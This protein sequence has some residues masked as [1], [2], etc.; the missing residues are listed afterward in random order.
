MKRVL[1]FFMA[2]VFMFALKS[3]AQVPVEIHNS[4]GA[5]SVLNPF[6]V[7]F[8]GSI[9]VESPLAIIDNGGSITVD[10]AGTFAVQAAQSGVWSVGISGAVTVSA[11][12]LDMRDLTATSDSIRIYANTAK[13][14]SG[15]NYVP[16]VDSDGQLQVD[17]L[18]M[19]AIT[20][21][22]AYDTQL[23]QFKFTGSFDGGGFT[24]SDLYIDRSSTDCVG[25]FGEIGTGATVSNLNL[26]D[27]DITGKARTGALAG[28]NSGTV[29]SCTVSGG[30]VDGNG[31][32]A[33]GLIGHTGGTVPLCSANVAVVNTGYG[34]G[35]LVGRAYLATIT[36]SYAKGNV[37]GTYRV[38]G[39]IGDH[40]RSTSQNCYAWGN[41]TGNTTG[42]RVGGFV[43]ETVHSSDNIDYC[44]SKGKPTNSGTGGIGAFC[45]DAY[46]ETEITQCFYDSTTSETTVSEGGTA[47]TTAEMK[48]LSTFTGASWDIVDNSAYV[49]ENWKIVPTV[50]YPMLGWEEYVIGIRKDSFFHF[51]LQ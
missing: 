50:T 43:G 33:G 19:P 11:T 17:V 3:F 40:N 48:T 15:T 16:L 21:V 36:K 47:K 9:E 6:P 32:Y 14:G 23:E 18:T 37:T 2:I 26:E 42:I 1:W 25:L 12:N 39:F 22:T 13:D 41:V 4:T 29:T 5:I 31:I 49:D 20:D 28:K 38:G 35:G 51:L 27:V 44:Y 8:S 30:T 24:I 34:T 7:T 46:Y 45:G 10:N